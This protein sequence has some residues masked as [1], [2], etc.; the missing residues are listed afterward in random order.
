[1]TY[2][3]PELPY[4]YSALEP[5]ISGEIIELHHD[6][7][8]AAYVAG[9]NRTLEQLEEARATDAFAAIV[10]LEK[11][12]AFNLSGHVLHSIY[13]ENMRPDGGGRPEGAFADAI[14]TGSGHSTP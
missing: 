2:T 3:L 8:H 11:A 13:W 5:H 9:A 4:G 7:H 6:K 12:L 14:E 10:G 1:V